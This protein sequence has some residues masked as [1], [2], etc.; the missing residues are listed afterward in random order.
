M[1]Y[2]RNVNDVLSLFN[3]SEGFVTVCAPMV[4]YSKIQFRSL[5]RQ[6]NCDL[7]FSPMI[8]ADSFCKSEKARQNEFS[9][10]RNDS[11]VVVQ[12][13]ANNAADFVEAANLVAP[14]CDGVDLNCGCPQRWAKQLGVGCALLEDPQNI[15]NIV[16]ECKNQVTKPFT[17]SVKMRLLNDLKETVTI[18]KQLEM[19]GVS[20]ITLHGR[21][22]LQQKGEAN[23]NAIK[24]VRESINCPLISNGG[25][26][27][28]DGCKEMHEKTGCKGVMVGN[29]ILTNPTL[30]SGSNT[31]TIAC[32]QSWIDICYNS[33][34]TLEKYNILRQSKQIQNPVIPERPLNLTFQCFHHHLVFMLEKILPRFKRRIFNGLQTFSTVLHFLKENLGLT[35][36]LFDEETFMNSCV[37]DINYYNFLN[38]CTEINY[39]NHQNEGKFFSEKCTFSDVYDEEENILNI[40]SE[41]TK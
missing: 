34:L 35:C 22:K 8:M 26:L 27:D 23:I 13:A 10:N 29:G 14:Y 4:R 16:R 19:C 7:C 18:C 1:I 6:Y 39:Y 21:T 32:V 40:F 17:I 9:T 3:N 30:F 5:V 15:Y 37:L 20:F 2:N 11:P 28:L 12:F 38:N 33:T 36:K 31:T 41:T 24:T 25:V